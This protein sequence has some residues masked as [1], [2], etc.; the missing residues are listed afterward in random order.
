MLKKIR[1]SADFKKLHCIT[2]L[3]GPGRV[4]KLGPQAGRAEIFKPGGMNRAKRTCDF[5]GWAE[6]WD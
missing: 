6:P 3:D 5:D 1:L 4:R 2:G